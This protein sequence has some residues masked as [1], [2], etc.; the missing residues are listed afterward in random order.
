MRVYRLS[1]LY[2]SLS[3]VK[4]IALS[5]QCT[6]VLNSDGISIGRMFFFT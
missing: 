2:V 5:Q 6:D 1:M 3:F 4:S